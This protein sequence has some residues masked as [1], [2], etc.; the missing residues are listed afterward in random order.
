MASPSIAPDRRI[1]R[2]DLVY[3]R[4]SAWPAQFAAREGLGDPEVDRWIAQGWPLVGTRKVLGVDGVA[5]GMPLPPTSAKRRRSFVI[6]AADILATRAAPR[7]SWAARVAPD[8]WRVTLKRLCDLGSRHGV[9]ARV[10]GSLAWGALTGLEYLTGRSDLDFLMPVSRDTDLNRLTAVLSEI[11][12]GA[13]MRLDG[14]LIREDGA[15]VNWREFGRGSDEVL[16][17]SMAG[18]RLIAPREFLAGS[19]LS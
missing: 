1:R 19:E 8:P 18:V 9:H 17:K 10:F 12:A 6:S 15:G 5:V 7:L 11:E 3:V 14:E 2:H 4:R 16:V 13:P